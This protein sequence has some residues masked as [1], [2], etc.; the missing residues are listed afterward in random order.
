MAL[1]EQ[2]TLVAGL[3]L[4]SQIDAYLAGNRKMRQFGFDV[5][6]VKAICKSAYEGLTVTE[7][8]PS[9]STSSAF[10][11]TA[12]PCMISSSEST[13]RRAGI[14]AQQ[15]SS[16]ISQRSLHDSHFLPGYEIGVGLEFAL[17]QA[18]TQ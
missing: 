10:T 8:S 18:A 13:T 17:I 3:W 11:S 5:C 1:T 14:C 2:W 16:E 12:T 4:L 9:A 6:V 7:F 15:N